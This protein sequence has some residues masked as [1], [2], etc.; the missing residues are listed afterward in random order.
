MSH[1][2]GC[3]SSLGLSKFSLEKTHGDF[4]RCRDLKL[5]GFLEKDLLPFRI[6]LR[7]VRGG[8]LGLVEEARQLLLFY[9]LVTLGWFYQDLGSL[10]S[11]CFFV[12]IS[13]VKQSAPT[14]AGHQVIPVLLLG[15]ED[16][17]LVAPGKFRELF[18]RQSL[19]GYGHFRLH[20]VNY[21]LELSL[22]LLGLTQVILVKVKFWL[23]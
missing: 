21:F 22:D 7:L 6:E 16:L 15:L 20:L 11:L 12:G 1:P 4:I 10:L 14:L 9:S 8:L 17:L 2:N 23:K 3:I 13:G 19:V 5:S 18:D